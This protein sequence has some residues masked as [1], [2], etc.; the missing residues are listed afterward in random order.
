MA[1]SQSIERACRRYEEVQAEGLTL[2]PILVEEME[3]F[4]L[5]RDRKSVV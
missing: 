2:Y 4:E 5:A 1:I 3:T